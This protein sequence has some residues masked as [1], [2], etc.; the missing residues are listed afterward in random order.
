ML[1][2]TQIT[3]IIPTLNNQAGL[4]QLLTELSVAEIPVVVVNNNR[5]QMTDDGLPKNKITIIE[6]PKNLG[7][8]GAVNLG[9]K[10]AKTEWLLILNDDVKG[11]T[12]QSVNPS[13]SS[14]LSQLIRQ[15]VDHDW[16]AISPVLVN[17][18]GKIEN[19][20]YQ[21][22]PVGK[23]K[24]NFDKTKNTDQDL[25]GL[26]AA[27]LLIKTKVF[28]QLKGFDESFFAYLE[29][30]DLF[31]RLKGDGYNFGIDIKTEVIHRHQTTSQTL[32][33]NF[34]QKQDLINWWRIV[35]KHPRRFIFQPQ[36]LGML[37]ERGRNASGYLKAH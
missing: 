23:V 12:R 18:E 26:T 1:P 3:A 32:K 36:I 31:L 5:L 4:R 22:L 17:P 9:A 24:L 35:F 8:A 10:D 2:L 13:A 30:V 20:G 15:A 34:K 25:D 37:V 16:V 6:T 7:F 28:K 29:D 14:G 21:V 27:C 33:K 11:L 19:I